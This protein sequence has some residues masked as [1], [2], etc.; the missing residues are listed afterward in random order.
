VVTQVVGLANAY[1]GDTLGAA[2]CVAPSVFNARLQ[3]PWY[4]GR[5]VFLEPPYLGL[6]RGTWQLATRPTWLTQDK[7]GGAAATSGTW[8]DLDQVLASARDD[9]DL[10]RDY[11]WAN[12]Y[13]RTGLRSTGCGLKHW[14]HECQHHCSHMLACW[15]SCRQYIDRVL[16]SHTSAQ[17][18]GSHLAALII[19]PLVQGA[20]GMLLV[21]PQFQRQLVQVRELVLSRAG[22][23]RHVS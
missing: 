2:D 23:H 1:H 18:P 15:P 22:G 12:S 8:Q 17:P 9:S 16:D 4:Q 10:T 20:G 5:G 11:R 7:S 14:Q 21:D 3:A 6:V 13:R 19:E